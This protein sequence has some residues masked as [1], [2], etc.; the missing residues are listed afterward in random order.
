M[1]ILVK[2][3]NQS[4]KRMTVN[5]LQR[6]VEEEVAN[7]KMTDKANAA[8]FVVGSSACALFGSTVYDGKVTLIDAQNE[9]N[10]GHKLKRQQQRKER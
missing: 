7:K 2:V 10:E 1:S 9:C 4:K 8:G 5:A 6:L 3:N